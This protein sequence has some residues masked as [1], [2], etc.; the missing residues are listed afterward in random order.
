MRLIS[1]KK[2]SDLEV[3]QPVTGQWRISD[4]LKIYP[5]LLDT[6]V[7]TTPA[8]EKLRNP[9]LRKVQSRLITV[10]QAAG[11]AGIE[12]RALISRLNAAAGLDVATDDDP[13]SEDDTPVASDQPTWLDDVTVA[14]ELDARPFQERGEEP[15]SAIME[16]SRQIPE[17]QAFLLLNSFEP[18]PLYDVLGMRGFEHWTE[19]NAPDE[20]RI[21]FFHSGKKLAPKTA[22]ERKQPAP[23]VSESDWGSADASVTI[24]VSELVPPEP[25]IKIMEALESLPDGS[26]LLVHHVRRPMHLYPQ[27]DTMGYRHDTRELAPDQIEVLIQKPPFAEAAP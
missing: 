12:P 20:W 16:V 10:E 8:F 15:F 13:D 19:F 9:A 11:I 27:L 23:P 3:G 24:D 7:E 17:G 25:L 14:Q 2:E 1:R 21:W 6:L 18:V 4:V 5:D 22:G 26:S